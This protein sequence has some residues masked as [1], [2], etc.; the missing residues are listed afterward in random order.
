MNINE[1]VEILKCGGI[2]V[3]P[4]DTVYGI[5]CDALCISSVKKVYE[6]KSRPYSKPMVILVSNIDML[7]KYSSNI[8]K[9]ESSLIKTYMPGELTIILNKSDL[10]P[11]IVTSNTKEVA[12]R[13]PNNEKLLEIINKLDRPIVATSAN[14]S[15]HE[16]I[17]NVSLLED[18]IKNNVDYIYDGGY[19]NKSSSTIVKVNDNK[20]S[21][22][23]EGSLIADI[24]VKFKNYL[25]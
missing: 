20:I 3:L 8:S 2:A 19:V 14:I 9:L 22:L 17:T 21:I 11:D 5:V 23:R 4:T 15:S 24:R 7:K 13:I 10:I 6:L 18:S 16:V 12:I 1:V 25:N